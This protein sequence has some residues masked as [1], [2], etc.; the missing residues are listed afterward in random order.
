MTSVSLVIEVP[1]LREADAFT[2]V[3]RETAWFATVARRSI[4]S[5]SNPR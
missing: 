1:A 2:A 4:L 3:L 5:L